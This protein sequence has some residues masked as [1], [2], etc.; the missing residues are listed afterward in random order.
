MFVPTVAPLL[1]HASALERQ[2]DHILGAPSGRGGL[3]GGRRT[4]PGQQVGLGVG[5]PTRDVGG[6][7]VGG[8]LRSR[9]L[10]RAPVHS[11]RPG[12]RRRWTIWDCRQGLLEPDQVREALHERQRRHQARAAQAERREK[13]T[14]EVSLHRAPESQRNSGTRW[15]AR[16]RIREVPHSHIHAGVAAPD[17]GRRCPRRPRSRWTPDRADSP[18]HAGAG[19]SSW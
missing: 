5:R 1:A 10:R 11:R 4:H 15:S 6:A 19:T 18:L 7:G 3:V 17:R 16:S 8:A 2:R 13:V 12:R 9:P 14:P